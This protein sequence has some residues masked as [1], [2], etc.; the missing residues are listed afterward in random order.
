MAETLPPKITLKAARTNVGLTAKEVAEM[1]G[2]NYQTILSYE[3]DSEN[4]PTSLL[5]KLSEIYHYP[6][7]FIFLGKSY[8]LNSTID[9]AS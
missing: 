8:R 6:M 4:I 7:D 3:K 2:K 5:I 9:K 1:V